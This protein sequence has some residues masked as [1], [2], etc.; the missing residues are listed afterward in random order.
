MRP[1]INFNQI[2][3]L[4]KYVYGESSGSYGVI[5]DYTIKN[6]SSREYVELSLNSDTISGN[7]LPK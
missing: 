6:S 1:A 4:S 7:F 3:V 5:D 2:E